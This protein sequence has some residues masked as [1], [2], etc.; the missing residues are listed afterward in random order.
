MTADLVPQ[1]A[2][3]DP[4]GAG[5]GS[6]TGGE[7]AADLAARS[8]LFE[9]EA[10]RWLPHVARFAMSLTHSRPD[11]DD[12]VQ[13]TYLKAFR[14]W[15]TFHEGADARRWLF[16][17]CKRSFL[18]AREREQRTVEVDGDPELETLA[19]VR[20]HA[21]AVRSGAGDL[22]DRLDLA[23]AIERAMVGLPEHYRVVA[24]VV[25]VEG[26]GYED[27]AALLELPVGTIR[28]RLFRARRLLQESLFEYARDAG[29]A[30]PRAAD[31]SSR[32]LRADQEPR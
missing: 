30:L 26:Y 12:L 21:S 31:P 19:A 3:D 16:T 17:I 6:V 4:T 20:M 10:L 1:H 24:V 9:Q 18:Q 14:S 29:F 22:W 25:D 5:P 11:A 15:R 28:S 8:Q 7:A 13:E 2:P 32:P 27:A 23:P